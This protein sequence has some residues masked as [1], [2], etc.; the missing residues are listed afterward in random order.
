MV[1]S[2]AVFNG[3]VIVHKDAQKIEAHQNNANLFYQMM[4]RLI[5]SLN[6]RFMR[7]M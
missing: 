1:K 3:K 4:Q 6:L 2:R 7:M 5:P